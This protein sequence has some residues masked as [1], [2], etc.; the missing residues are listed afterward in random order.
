MAEKK[1]TSKRSTKGPAK[2]RVAETAN[3][4]RP[5]A[6]TECAMSGPSDEEVARKAYAL[7]E[8]RGKPIGSPDDDWYQAQKE[9][10]ATELRIGLG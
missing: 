5:H 1:T 4:S 2:P 7:W 9:L 6:N 3:N 8:N 10:V